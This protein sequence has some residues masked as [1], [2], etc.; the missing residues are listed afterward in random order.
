M[1]VYFPSLSSERA[2]TSPSESAIIVT[3]VVECLRYCILHHTE[4]G[5]DQTKL[6]T[7]LISQQVGSHNPKLSIVLNLLESLAFLHCCVCLF[8]APATPGK[9]SG[10]YLPSEWSSFPSGH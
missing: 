7:M 6:R 3:S 5:E 10:K 9:G 4:E 8:V 1:F 2:A